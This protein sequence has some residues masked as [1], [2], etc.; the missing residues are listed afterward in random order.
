MS[1]DNKTEKDK[2]EESQWEIMK[3]IKK[4]GFIV[5][6][7]GGKITAIIPRRRT[8]LKKL[9]SGQLEILELIK[10]L[11]AEQRKKVIAF[12]NKIKRE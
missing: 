7:W 10:D 1:E 5:E 12:I 9:T 2:G 8:D 6:E 4:L 3:R 11:S